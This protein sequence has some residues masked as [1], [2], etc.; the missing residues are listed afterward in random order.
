M[1]RPKT[2]LSS[3]A[4]DAQIAEIQAARDAEIARLLERRR[5]A[6]QAEHLR[7]G[8]LLARYLAGPHGE[9]IRRALGPAVAPQHRALF[10]LDRG[11]DAAPD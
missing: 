3:A 5:E 6:E 8:E 2:T 11:A 1:T 10:A 7:R 9:A 4:L